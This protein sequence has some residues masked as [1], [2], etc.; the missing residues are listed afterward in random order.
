MPRIKGLNTNMNSMTALKSRELIVSEVAEN[1]IASEIIKIANEVNEKIK[2][3]EKIYNLTIGDFN[4]NI[5]PIP[6]GLKAEIIKAYENN[7]TNYPQANGIPEL[8][9]SVSYYLKRKGNLD[10]NENQILISAGARP[11]IY[12][13]FT[14]LL[15]KGDTVIYPVPSW[16]NNHYTHLSSCKKVELETTPENKFMPSANDLK[17]YLSEATLIALCSP[18]NP[19][20][21]MFSKEGLEEICD[22]ILEENASREEGRKPLYLMYDQIYW[23][24]TM[25]GNKHYDP[26]S[27]RPEMR[28]YTIYVDGISKAFAST[29]VRVGWAFGPQKIIDKMRALLS[30][31]GA[32][33]PKAEQVATAKFLEREDETNQYLEWINKSVA[34]RLAGFYNGFQSLKNEGFAVDAIAPQGAMYLT[35]QFSLHGYKTA[36]GKKLA[37]TQDITSYLLDEAKTALVPFYAFGTSPES[38]W[39]RLSI[40][41]IK[42][43]EIEQVIAQLRLALSKLNKG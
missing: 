5:F 41:T 33:S 25:S 39:Y 18:L 11:L 32:W 20:G 21:T 43:E 31:V 15:D 23:G 4:S 2:K 28:N 16:N 22:L 13:T 7:Q 36:Q 30:H 37:T 14:A 40:G 29:G 1:L 26:V 35:V 6:Q 10:Y 24:L 17:P 8:R 12:A 38:N 34:E 42:T 9:K 27:L 3:G 19:T